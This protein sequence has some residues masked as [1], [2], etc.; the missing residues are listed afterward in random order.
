MNQLTTTNQFKLEETLMQRV[1]EVSG[2]QFTIVTA[3]DSEPH[4]IAKEIAEGLDY[5]RNDYLTVPLRQS[6]LP[7]LKLTKENGLNVLKTVSPISK[8]TR[9]LMLIP[10]SSLQEYCLRHSTKPKAKPKA[11]AKELGDKLYEVLSK[12]ST[13]QPTVIEQPLDEVEQLIMKLYPSHSESIEVSKEIQGLFESFV[14]VDP[15]YFNWN[16]SFRKESVYG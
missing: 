14:E 15:G 11:K 5:A 8:N 16:P 1:F 13:V 2:Y 4:F 10:A 12:S 6:G 9:S 7:L 3:N